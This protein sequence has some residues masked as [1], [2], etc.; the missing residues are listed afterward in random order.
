MEWL[1]TPAAIPP[2]PRTTFVA[3]QNGTATGARTFVVCFG[4][5]SFARLVHSAGL[6]TRGFEM[7]CCRLHTHA[8]CGDARA[9]IVMQSA[10]DP[11]TTAVVS[12]VSAGGIRFL[13]LCT[14][15][16]AEDAVLA[17]VGLVFAAV[18][19][20]ITVAVLSYWMPD[21]LWTIGMS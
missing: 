9:R 19:H 3:L 21:T 2:A 4:V 20:T 6:S 14:N 15:I 7:V 5:A 8:S 12:A 10:Q 11:L 16:H 13:L 18:N 17:W 1:V